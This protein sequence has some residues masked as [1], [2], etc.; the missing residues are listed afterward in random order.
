MSKTSPNPF[1]QT[2]IWC[3][4]SGYAMEGKIKQPFNLLMFHMLASQN[5]W[6]VNEG[7]QTP[8]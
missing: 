3:G 6:K 8:L 7:I 1:F 4:G 5:S 2:K